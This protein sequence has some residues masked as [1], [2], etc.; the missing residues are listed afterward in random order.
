M[1]A[2]LFVVNGEHFKKEPFEN[3]N[4]NNQMIS[5]P[6]FTSI[7][8]QNDRRLLLTSLAECGRNLEAILWES[9]R[10]LSYT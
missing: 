5:L 9:V 8:I 4:A 1:G 7:T 2:F 6:K 3:N 10:F